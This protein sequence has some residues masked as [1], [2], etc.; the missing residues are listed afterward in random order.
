[1]EKEIRQSYPLQLLEWELTGSH[2]S[3]TLTTSEIQ[4][5]LDNI[6][7]FTK[8][9]I[10]WTGKEC[11]KRSDLYTITR[12]CE[13]LGF[14]MHLDPLTNDLSFSIVREI[15][16]NGIRSLVIRLDG[17]SAEHHDE[18][19]GIGDFDMAQATIEFSRQVNLPF[20][21]TTT[22]T[23]KNMQDLPLILDLVIRSNAA[24]FH[25]YVLIP[26]DQ[27]DAKFC[28]SGKEYEETLIWLTRQREL[29]PSWFGF[30]PTCA[31]QYYR[32]IRQQEITNQPVPFNE[33]QQEEPVN[34]GCTG[35]RYYAYITGEGI[36]QTCG[37]L[38]IT[39][40]SLK[41]A[42]FDFQS[43]WEQSHLF[44][45]LRDANSYTGRCRRCEYNTICG[46]C[47]ARAYITTGDYLAAEPL[48]MYEPGTDS[49]K[50]GGAGGVSINAA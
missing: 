26:G 28:L 45:M 12:Y 35:G 41:S 43:I 42:R 11:L 7:R 15:V 3:G 9:V 34:H 2:G 50:K 48:C 37:E 30:Q 44:Q 5:V 23:R 20:S 13:S 49:R 18:I 24:A 6:A 4:Q 39:A 27:N 40:G 36:V 38:A 17:A 10:V 22:I 25:P 19:R 16:Q 33:V 1:M 47:R 8:P 32:I 46:G 21:I 31:P 14:E 29:V